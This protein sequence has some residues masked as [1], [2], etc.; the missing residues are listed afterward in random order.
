V[1]PISAR[2]GKALTLLGGNGR[3]LPEN[4]PFLRED[5]C[6]NRRKMAD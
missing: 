3:F 6:K 4:A 1:S 2:L 5:A